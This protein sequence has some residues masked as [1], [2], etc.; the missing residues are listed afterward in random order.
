MEGKWRA[1][2]GQ[3]EGPSRHS[4]PLT[5]VVEDL[6]YNPFIGGDRVAGVNRALPFGGT[7]KMGVE[8]RVTCPYMVTMSQPE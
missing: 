2:G 1:N 7:C 3:M 6:I 4:L 8:S 5:V